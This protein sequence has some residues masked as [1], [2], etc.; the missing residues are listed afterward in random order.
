[1][2]SRAPRHADAAH[3][4]CDDPARALDI[5]L[6]L[7]Y[8]HSQQQQP[9]LAA[10]AAAATA[11][12]A[13]SVVVGGV[14][15]VG[16][17][18]ASAASASAAAR[19][20]SAAATALSASQMLSALELL[21]PQKGG[22]LPEMLLPPKTAPEAARGAFP[23]VAIARRLQHATLSLLPPAADFRRGPTA[24]NAA[25]GILIRCCAV[26]HA[27]LD[28]PYDRMAR[29]RRSEATRGRSAAL[30]L[31]SP[32]AIAP[33]ATAL[34]RERRRRARPAVA[35]AV[36]AAAAARIKPRTSK[37]KATRSG[38]S[39]RRDGR[40]RA[41]P[42]VRDHRAPRARARA[43]DFPPH[44]P[45]FGPIVASC[46]ASRR[47]TPLHVALGDIARLPEAR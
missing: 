45:A 46:E 7:H 37:R 42:R 43:P 18:A 26:L 11:I 31:R 24:R 3:F 17:S 6:L 21:M 14:G 9:A 12:A 44:A 29:A 41:A 38:A 22:L 30:A 34:P 15:G 40:G 32:D 13:D 2:P 20:P 4:L 27:T 10:L 5:L 19:R 25:S 23:L 39:A 36:A 1:M 8:A 33:L 28:A 35:Q 47:N 16:V